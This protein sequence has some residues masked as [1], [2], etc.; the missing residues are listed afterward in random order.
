M[1]EPHMDPHDSQN[2]ADSPK[3]GQASAP[4]ENASKGIFSRKRWIFFG[5]LALFFV[6]AYCVVNR[7]RLA[8]FFSSAGFSGRPLK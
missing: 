5:V 2:P 4:T 7:D 8:S 3:A 1:T 6:V